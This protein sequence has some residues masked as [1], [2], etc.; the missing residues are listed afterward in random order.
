MPKDNLHPELIK[1]KKFVK[2]HPGLVAEVR[3]GKQEWQYY[4]DQWSKL[5]ETNQFWNDYRKDVKS[6][7]HEQPKSEE[8][9]N[10]EN[11]S[12][13]Q[14]WYKQMADLV[15]KI[16]LTNMEEH[17]NQLD[18]AFASVRSLID[19]FKSSS[20]PNQASQSNPSPNQQA[21]TR[22]NQQPNYPQHPYYQNRTWF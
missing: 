7:N 15:N 12:N 16:D 22:P 9:E 11:D 19:Q 18:S 21:Q 6:K 2:E 17:V 4:F 5:G 20:A 3:Q 1:F 8:E 10:N 13:K 14:A